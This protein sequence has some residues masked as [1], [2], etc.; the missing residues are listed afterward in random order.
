M[1][2]LS[3]FLLLLLLVSC[4]SSFLDVKP[5]TQAVVPSSISDYELLLRDLVILTTYSPNGLNLIAG[6]EYTLSESKF[7]IFEMSPTG[8]YERNAFTW[9]AKIYSG[10][11]TNTDWTLGYRRIL[12]CN[13]VL[14]GLDNLKPSVEEQEKYNYVKGSA[15]FHRA[16]NYYLLAQ[17]Y[18]PVYVSEEQAKKAL[19]LPLRKKG[20]PTVSTERASLWD[21]YQFIEAELLQSLT[22]IPKQLPQVSKGDPTQAACMA[23][24]VKLYMQ[25]GNFTEAE[26]QATACL[27][28]NYSL[29]NYADIP[30]DTENG[31]SLNGKDNPEVIFLNSARGHNII[32]DYFHFIPQEQLGLYDPKD[33]RLPLFY[34]ESGAGV[35][36]YKANYT[37]NIFTPFTGLALDEVYLNLV[38]CLAR[39]GEKIESLRLLNAL[40]ENRFYQTDFIPYVNLSADEILLSA[41]GERRRQLVFRGTRWEDLRR[42]NKE[43]RFKQTVVRKVGTKEFLLTPESNRWVWPIPEAAITNGGYQ[44][45][46][47]E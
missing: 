1:R 17:M 20:D 43:E 30:V 27:A 45:N 10:E 32:S 42:L 16:Y 5:S 33:L 47:R 21:T 6:D 40:R 23:L 7:N 13:V 14:D 9:S 22:L 28:T 41:L 29:L 39:R 8:G 11:E 2:N 25:M 36:I 44:Q 24:L 37:G 15:L 26:K 4:Q 46:I 31:F 19:G 18:C 38:E 35:K 34:K 12:Q 3:I